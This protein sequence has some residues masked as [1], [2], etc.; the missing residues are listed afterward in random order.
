MKLFTIILQVVSFGWLPAYSQ[1]CWQ[2]QVKNKQR[3]DILEGFIF[4][5]QQGKHITLDQGI[6]HLK[7]FTDTLGRE[8]WVLSTHR[9]D[10]YKCASPL[11][12]SYFL[13]KDTPVLILRGMDKEQPLDSIQTQL[14]TKCLEEVTKGRVGPK[15]PPKKEWVWMTETDEKGRPTLDANGNKIRH[16]VEVK[17]LYNHGPTPMTYQYIFGKD[18]S[19]RR[20]VPLKYLD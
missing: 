6:V 3:L 2:E 11:P 17:S 9:D 10:S 20:Q 8:T 14:S 7:E 5:A 16:R 18:G 4:Q 13:V 12:R 15:P 19:V 1:S